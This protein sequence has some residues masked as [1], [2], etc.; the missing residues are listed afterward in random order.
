MPP[1]QNFPLIFSPLCDDKEYNV[2]KSRCWKFAEKKLQYTTSLYR[3]KIVQKIVAIS[4]YWKGE[5]NMNLS[6]S[7]FSKVVLPIWISVLAFWNLKKKFCTF[8]EKSEPHRTLSATILFAQIVLSL[9]RARRFHEIKEFTKNDV[10]MS[11]EEIEMV[12]YGQ[13][14]SIRVKIHNVSNKSRTLKVMVKSSSVQYNGVSG[15][16]IRKSSGEFVMGP[17]QSN[18]HI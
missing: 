12:K 18:L 4:D 17:G 11:L 1:I 10:I 9:F 14:Y 13:P 5:K 16:L 15:H 7:K 3:T 2:V 8:F 6:N